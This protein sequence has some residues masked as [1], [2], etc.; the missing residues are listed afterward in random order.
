MASRAGNAEKRGAPPFALAPRL[1]SGSSGNVESAGG[2][3][4]AS[5][6]R[7]PAMVAAA[8]MPAVV[9]GDPTVPEAEVAT[10]GAASSSV[11]NQGPSPFRCR[12]SNEAKSNLLWKPFSYDARK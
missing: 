9:A 4:G 10:V 7:A 1:R 5:Q 12:M 3:E 8:T 11:R 2:G 6:A